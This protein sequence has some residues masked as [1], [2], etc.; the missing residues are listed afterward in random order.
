[1]TSL[2]SPLAVISVVGFIIAA[3]LR[4]FSD[5]DRRVTNTFLVLVV[6]LSGYLRIDGLRKMF[7]DEMLGFSALANT[8]IQ[9]N[10]IFASLFII[11]MD[12][13]TIIDPTNA[14]V[15][16]ILYSVDTTTTNGS[17]GITPS[18]KATKTTHTIN[19]LDSYILLITLGFYV[20]RNVASIA[21]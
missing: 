13:Y 15:D 12:D 2:T 21:G 4:V 19:L 20:V 1:M 11:Y 17:S 7:R 16:S 3:S 6:L 18:T 9:H 14:M 5:I 8:F 10:I